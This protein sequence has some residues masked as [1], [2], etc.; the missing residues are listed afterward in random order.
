MLYIPFLNHVAIVQ[1]Y[2]FLASFDIESAQGRG[3]RRGTAPCN[4]PTATRSGA[5]G[6]QVNLPLIPELMPPLPSLPVKG[7]VASFQTP[8]MLA[9]AATKPLAR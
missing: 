1:I 7:P 9:G 8:V 3:G 2:S 5:A 6:D 4:A